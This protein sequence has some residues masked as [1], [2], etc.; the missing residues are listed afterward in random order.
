MTPFKIDLVRDA[1]CAFGLA[2]SCQSAGATELAADIQ[3]NG[4]NVPFST[5][6]TTLMPGEALDWQT[7]ANIRARINGERVSAWR[8]PMEAGT[9]TLNFE[10]GSE[11]VT[12]ITVFVLEPAS[13]IDKSGALN[14]YKIGTYPRARPEGFIRLDSADDYATAISPSFKVGQFICKQ[15]PNHFPKYVLVSKPNLKRSEALLESLKEDG[16]T[17]ADTFFVMSGFRTPFYNTAIGSAKFS[18]H[19]YGDAFDI[20]VDVSPRDGVMDDLNKDGR[21]TKADAN[22]LYDYAAEL[23]AERDDLPKGGIGA[24][25]SNAAHGP[26]VHV[27]GRGSFARWG[28]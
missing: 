5:W 19:M 1:L 8:A 11:A 15:Q 26:F 24:Y 4:S 9:H 28:R 21:V 22:F 16:L 17:D 2:F 27:D 10:R 14:G 25:G 12:S 18:R 6:H 13:K 7:P 20:Y 23:F 3:V